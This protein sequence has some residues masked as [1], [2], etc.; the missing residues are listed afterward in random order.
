MSAGRRVGSPVV[1]Q[2]AGRRLPLRA[3]RL[4]ARALAL[5]TPQQVVA[6]F[7]VDR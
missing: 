1:K 2:S 7:C 4:D 6:V 3:A 5:A